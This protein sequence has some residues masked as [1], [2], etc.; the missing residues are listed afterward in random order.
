MSKHTVVFAVVVGS[1]LAAVP[2]VEGVTRESDLVGWW[3]MGEGAAWDGGASEWTVP[4]DSAYDGTATS[5]GLLETDVVAGYPFESHPGPSLAVQY[6][7]NGEYLQA[8]VQAAQTQSTSFTISAWG[9]VTQWVSG[10]YMYTVIDGFPNYLLSMAEAGM[11][12]YEGTPLEDHRVHAFVGGWAT[13]YFS[14]PYYSVEPDQWYHMVLLY[15]EPEAYLY[16]DG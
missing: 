11:A 15:D 10:D 16:K 12:E 9:K 13:G 1:V 7:D 2:A 4:D 14:E 5:S 8:A 3:K 6:N